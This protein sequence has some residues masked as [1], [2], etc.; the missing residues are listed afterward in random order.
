MKR[1]YEFEVIIPRCVFTI[2]SEASIN[3]L[4]SQFE[5]F[6]TYKGSDDDKLEYLV[7]CPSAAVVVPVR[8][9]LAKISALVV[10]SASFVSDKK[11]LGG[12]LYGQVRL[13]D[14]ANF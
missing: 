3:I 11:K 4:L 5:V 1:S 7:S 6:M 9:L 10:A 14:S 12:W 13:F 2:I 8:N